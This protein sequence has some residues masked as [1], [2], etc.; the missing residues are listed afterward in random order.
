MRKYKVRVEL[1]MCLSA[2]DEQDAME[3]A[4]QHWS[5]NPFE[6]LHDAV[7]VEEDW[8]NPTEDML[9]ER[10]EAAEEGWEY[11]L[12]LL[13]KH[14]G[15]VHLAEPVYHDDGPNEYYGIQEYCY[16]TI[17]FNQDGDVIVR[18]DYDNGHDQ[19]TLDLKLDGHE[20]LIAEL[21]ERLEQCGVDEDED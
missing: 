2:V 10:K 5:E 3:Q 14:G 20:A 21:H 18:Y 15:R 7:E 4:I 13:E 17:G 12:N 9:R 6:T 1:E 16:H 19:D 11:I 8:N